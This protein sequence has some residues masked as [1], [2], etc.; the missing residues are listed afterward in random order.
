M[1]TECIGH[2][3]SLLCP[4]PTAT[5]F[6]TID[7]MPGSPPDPGAAVPQPASAERTW[8]VVVIGVSGSGKSTIGERLAD[9]LGAG[10][11]DGDSLHSDANVAKMAAGTPLDDA[12]RWPWLTRVRDEL[13]H[14][15]RIVLACS[16]LR[17]DYRDHL[18]G[19]NGV[20]F[21]YLA[22]DPSTAKER[23]SGRRDHFMRSDMVDSQFDTLEPPA[24]DEHDVVAVDATADIETVVRASLAGL[25]ETWSGTVP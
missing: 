15:D 8:R 13:R 4:R 1:R 25:A 14:S 11:V 10:F 3:V 12:D 23:T 20:R 19:A 17:R 16:A 2:P 22:V 9:E 5:V 6:G 7:G 18:R 21:L 24:D